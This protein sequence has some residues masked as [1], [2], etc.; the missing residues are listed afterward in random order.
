MLLLLLF[1]SL[2]QKLTNIVEA[3]DLSLILL[4]PEKLFE[5]A[6]CIQH[7]DE[8]V[9]QLHSSHVLANDDATGGGVARLDR[10]GCEFKN[11]RGLGELDG[12]FRACCEVFAALVDVLSCLGKLANGRDEVG[13][14]R[15]KFNDVAKWFESHCGATGDWVGVWVCSGVG[16]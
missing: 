5:L 1:L 7:V 16:V 11:E 12:V 9:A 2:F 8:H 3:F 6:F 15:R 4:A 10:P 13:S 14:L